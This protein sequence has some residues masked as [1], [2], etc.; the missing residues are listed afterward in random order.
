M[1]RAVGLGWVVEMCCR[2]RICMVAALV[3]PGWRTDT[4]GSARLGDVNVA[5]VPAAW[6]HNRNHRPC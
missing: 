5:S 6:G 4:C 2:Q 3:G 1:K